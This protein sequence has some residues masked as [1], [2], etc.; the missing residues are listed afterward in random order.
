MQQAGS[1]A[2]A[3]TMRARAA[4]LAAAW[5]EAAAATT[6]L[7][8]ERAILRL[9]G[10]G[11][12]AS[13]GRPLVVE[14]ASRYF[15]ANPGRLA[16][17]IALPFAAELALGGLTPVALARAVADGSVD[18]ASAAAGL[19]NPAARAAAGR[20]A[21]GLAAATLE[22]MDAN[23]T[24]RGE[25]RAML[26]EP[27]R[28]LLGAM[29]APMPLGRATL[30]VASA[31][32][33][34]A[35]LVVL[36]SGDAE[37]E[38]E[39]E[40]EGELT[41]VPANS[42]PGLAGLR[43]QLDEAGAIRGGYVRLGVEIDALAADQAVAAGLER[44]DLATVD[45]M[46]A[47]VAG[48]ASPGHAIADHLFACRVLARAGVDILVP[49]GPLVVAPDLQSGIA[50]SPAVRSGRAVAIQLLA[51]ALAECAGV[52]RRRITVAGLPAWLADEPGAMSHAVAELATRRVLFHG[53][54]VALT[55]SDGTPEDAAT[56]RALVTLLIADGE[57]DLVIARH[58][59]AIDPIRGAADVASRVRG[60]RHA[61]ALTD[62]AAAYRDA[63][64]EAAG[65]ELDALEVGGW[66]ALIGDPLEAAAGEPRSGV[67]IRTDGFDP[68]G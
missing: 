47:I 64:L 22:R 20:T 45:P 65:R 26:G 63:V 15:G 58:Q 14:V 42:A 57:I 5:S 39:A 46:V 60:S 30:A 18:L 11:G 61:G 19:A 41:A 56:W 28:P 54:Q 24:A 4:A 17:G 25:L 8:R 35:D 66:A 16:H 27:P 7:G 48:L 43:S 67:A 36:G 38:A 52:P 50:S 33:H 34:G 29:V 6:T 2:V 68:L 10:V 37:A 32:H 49:A 13:S 12:P 31:S 9:L 23:R 21:A 40:A 51:V 62:A 3:M 44:V 55:E 1:A 59:E 53:C